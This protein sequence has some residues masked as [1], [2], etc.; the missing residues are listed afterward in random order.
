IDAAV[1]LLEPKLAD[2][3]SISKT[4]SERPR[5]RIVPSGFFEQPAAQLH[6]AA[7]VKDDKP[8]QFVALLLGPFQ[9]K[10]DLA[11]SLVPAAL[12]DP[13]LEPVGSRAAEN[14]LP[15]HRRGECDRLLD[16]GSGR[17][18]PARMIEHGRQIQQ[19]LRAER[20]VI[21]KDPERLFQ[22]RG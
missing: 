1:P 11:G 10:L 19:E 5:L 14:V 15:A 9:E 2:F 6:A 22:T 12:V 8:P 3:D 20:G 21:S 4:G 7:V 17:A 18:W 16:D 13:D